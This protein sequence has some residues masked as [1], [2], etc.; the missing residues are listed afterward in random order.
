MKKIQK[1]YYLF[2]GN[3]YVPL[4]RLSGKYLSKYG[5]DIGDMVEITLSEGEISIHKLNLSDN[6]SD[7]KE[8]SNNYEPC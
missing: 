7:Q 6:N 8:R 5:L 1:I 2:Q 3:D 4:I